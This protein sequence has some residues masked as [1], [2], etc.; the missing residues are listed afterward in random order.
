M[1]I[2]LLLLTPFPVKKE[3]E[4]MTFGCLFVFLSTKISGSF[5]RHFRTK[6][7]RKTCVC[8]II[9]N[10]NLLFDLL[11]LVLAESSLLLGV[12]HY[13][14]FHVESFATAHSIHVLEGLVFRVCFLAKVQ[15]F[16]L[17]GGNPVRITTDCLQYKPDRQSRHVL[18]GGKCA[19]TLHIAQI[20]LVRVIH[21]FFVL[22]CLLKRS[23][24]ESKVSEGPP[25]V[26]VNYYLIISTTEATFKIN[27]YAQTHTPQKHRETNTSQWL[28]TSC[29]LAKPLVLLRI[30]S[31]KPKLSATGRRALTVKMS[32][33]SFI[34]SCRTRPSRFPR[35]PYTRPGTRHIQ[36]AC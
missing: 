26:K 25:V 16:F 21:L 20:L 14:L 1:H 8:H 28:K 31:P 13:L 3:S 27:N 36:S 7:T 23:C 9:S 11:S 19:N 30:S 2:L 34:S 33:P 10:G 12:L 6:K 15:I 24:S 29:G 17:R 22:V 5:Q 18:V 35:T 4:Q 32:V